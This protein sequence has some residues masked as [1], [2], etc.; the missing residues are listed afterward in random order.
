MLNFKKLAFHMH[1]QMQVYKFNNLGLPIIELNKKMRT[2][3]FASNGLD[4]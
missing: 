4:D 1:M 2:S 3:K